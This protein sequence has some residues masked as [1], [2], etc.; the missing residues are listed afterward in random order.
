MARDG[1]YF[2]IPLLAAAAALA[3]TGWRAPGLAVGLGA[4]FVAFFFRDPERKVP[5]GAGVIVSPADGRVVRVDHDT[6]GI[7]VSIFLSLFNVHVNRSPVGG[8]VRSVEYRK[9]AFHAAFK[10]VAS[11]ENERNTLV[12]ECTDF[13]VSCSQ[14]AGVLARRIVCWKAAGDRVARGERIGLI[15]FGSRVDVRVPSLARVTVRVGDRVRGGSSTLAV[16]ESVTESE[17][18]G[19]TARK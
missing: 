1:Y 16:M 4:L 11:V 14:I 3:W 9:G 5:T 17:T 18:P 13:E 15:R 7:L 10:P 8:Q 12:I 6:E 19:T 2:L